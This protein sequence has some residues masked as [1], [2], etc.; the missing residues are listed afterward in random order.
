[1]TTTS[2]EPK[3]HKGQK[4][5]IKSGQGTVWT[6]DYVIPPTGTQKRGYHLKA[7]HHNRD[8]DED[9]IVLAGEG[10]A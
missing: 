8:V 7:A 5:R 6:V 9:R 10:E 2:T 4:V 1:M 3:F